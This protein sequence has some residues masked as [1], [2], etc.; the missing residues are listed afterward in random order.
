MWDLWWTDCLWDRF[1]SEYIE[2]SVL[3]ECFIDMLHYVADM[4]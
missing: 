4:K 2:K 3:C 1:F